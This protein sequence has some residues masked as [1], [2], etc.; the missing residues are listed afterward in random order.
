MGSYRHLTR[1]DREQI[2]TLTAAGWSRRRIAEAI[3][4][5]PSTISRELR[6]NALESGRYSA[7]VADGAY[8]A[9]RQRPSRLESDQR[10]AG[11]VRQRLSESWSPQQI[12]GWLRSGSE[13]G[14]CAV[15]METIY[16]F[17]YRA[18]QR[19]EQVWR[20]L[21]RRHKRRRSPAARASRDTLRDRASIHER[22]GDVDDRGTLGHREGDLIICQRTRPVLVLHERKT[23]LTL[24]ARL[25][26]KGAA[27]TASVIMSILRRFDPALRQS[28]TFDNDTCFARHGWLREALQMT[29]F[30]AALG[31]VARSPLTLRRLRL[32]AEG[33]HRERQRQAA[34]LAA[35][36]DQ[37]RRT[38]GRRPPGDR[39]DLQPDT[40]EVPRIP[41][42]PPGPLQ[43]SRQRC[44]TA[45][46][47]MPLHFALELRAGPNVRT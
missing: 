26:G 47:L 39:H 33:R 25:T 19:L 7:H 3:G 35:T 23:R 17:I 21:A 14:L 10:L 8:M 12:S 9:R 40:P 45:L 46:R 30:G 28:I 18:G 38:L 36:P 41:H 37:P 43:G 27:E 4:K 16:A 15:A 42:A 11:F 20:F 31:P 24:A 34:P 22:P 29:T 6:R 13:P 1:E 5:A 2:A 32:L 44:Q